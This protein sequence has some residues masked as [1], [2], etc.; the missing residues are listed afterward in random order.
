[1]KTYVFKTYISILCQIRRDYCFDQL[2]NALSLYATVWQVATIAG[3]AAGGALLAWGGV[4]PIYV[5]DVLSFAAVIAA[6]TELME[7]GFIRSSQVDGE[8]RY[9]AVLLSRRRSRLAMSIDV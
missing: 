3:P 7:R 8:Y 4:T 2:P 5:L 1:M 9:K 6:L